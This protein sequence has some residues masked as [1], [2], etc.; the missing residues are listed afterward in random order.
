M[1]DQLKNLLKT[2]PG[3]YADLRYEIKKECYITFTSKE[4]TRLGSS[5]TDGYVVRVLKN[6]GFASVSFTKIEDAEISVKRAIEYAEIIGE[7][8]KNKPTK[9]SKNKVI[10][11][12][13]IPKLN[14]DPRLIPIDEKLELVRKYNDIP[15]KNNKVIATNIGYYELG[16]EKYFINS[17]GSEIRE[18]LITVRIGGLITSSDGKLIQNVRV[19]A[20]GSDGFHSIR[21]QEKNFEERTKIVVDLLKAKP[22]KGGVYN[23]IIN[24]DLTGVFTHEAF[25]HFSEADCIEN[26]PSM[27]EK[28]KLGQK[29]GNNILNIVDD[30]TM[31]NQLGFY[32]YDD[33]GVEVRRTQLI[34]DGVLVGRLHSRK[35]A[36]EFGEPISGHM[37]AEDFRYAP[38]IRM[39]NIFIEKGKDS[40]EDLIKKLG[41]GL[42]ILDSKGGQTAGE[43]FTFGAQYGY[44]VKNGKIGNMIRDIN[45]SGNLYETLNNISAIGNDFTLSKTG[46][47][48]KG[49]T[50]IRSCNGGPH[51]IINNTIIGGI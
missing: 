16:R 30:A 13:Y 39:G 3:D 26:S 6:G 10:K 20:G 1:F 7:G 11:D 17:E 32:K 27:R 23:C 35:T 22:V 49:Q 43:N 41:D 31:P 51:I 38:I 40:F 21:N 29:I 5:T 14:E 28:M 9:M 45:I 12:T 15:L 46:G 47:C 37:I 4:L 42:Y 19:A 33:E 24:P 2:L 44:E 18:D 36:A 25:G 48:G 34:K 50:N 8:N